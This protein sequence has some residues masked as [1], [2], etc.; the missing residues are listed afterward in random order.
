MNM[1]NAS[2]ET[3]QN[4]LITTIDNTTTKKNPFKYSVYY[5]NFLKY[6]QEKNENTSFTKNV[7]IIIT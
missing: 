4:Y 5:N 2:F 3:E 1:Y 7:I 6:I